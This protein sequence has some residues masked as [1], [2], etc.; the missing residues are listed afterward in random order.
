MRGDRL[1]KEFIVDGNNKGGRQIGRRRTK[2][3]AQRLA[4]RKKKKMKEAKPRGSVTWQTKE[5]GL[6]QERSKLPTRSRKCPPKR[7]KRGG[8]TGEENRRYLV[9]W[10]LDTPVQRKKLG[11]QSL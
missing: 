10:C 8:F 5:P 11:L 6:P 3:Q 4:D 9:K 1:Q 2:R 7:K